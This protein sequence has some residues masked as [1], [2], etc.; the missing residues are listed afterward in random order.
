MGQ[1]AIE[2]YYQW[3]QEVK[4]HLSMIHPSKKYVPFKSNQNRYTMNLDDSAHTDGYVRNTLGTI[5]AL[6]MDLKHA[7]LFDFLDE[8]LLQ[9]GM[10]VDRTIRSYSSSMEFQTDIKPTGKEKDSFII[11]NPDQSLH[12]AFG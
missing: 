1:S 11:V 10:K 9:L 5:F 6:G 8:L 7:Y 12:L 2:N 3:S 4:N